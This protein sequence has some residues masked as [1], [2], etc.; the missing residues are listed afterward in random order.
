MT[1]SHTEP[2]TNRDLLTATE[3]ECVA[4]GNAQGAGP[5]EGGANVAM[6]KAGGDGSD[7]G[8]YLTFQFK[9]VAV[10]TVS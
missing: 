5:A 1:R 8:M 3:L 10:K 9:L 4:G 6:R 2:R 7:H